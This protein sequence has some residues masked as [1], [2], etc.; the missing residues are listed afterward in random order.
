MTEIEALIARC[1]SGKPDIKTGSLRFFGDWFGRPG[2]NFH[3]IAKIDYQAQ[4]DCLLIRLDGGETLFVWQAKGIQADDH[5]FII[6]TASRVRW[7]WFYYGRPQTP[8]NLYYQQY[9][10]KDGEVEVTHNINWYY[11]VFNTSVS[12]P[13]VVLY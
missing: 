6:R 2:D 12:A 4:D 8:E 11:P 10:V 7:E 13:A 1:K 3:S 9:T 5:H